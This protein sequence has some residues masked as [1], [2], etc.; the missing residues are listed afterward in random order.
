MVS[1]PT[2]GL[3]RVALV[4]GAGAAVVLAIVGVAQGSQSSPQPLSATEPATSATA[5]TASAPPRR[6]PTPPAWVDV[7]PV[8]ASASSP[9][10]SQ[11]VSDWV[12]YATHVIAATVVDET[13]LPL[14]EDEAEHNDGYV[15]RTATLQID[16]VVWESAHSDLELPDRIEMTVMGWSL[17]DGERRP[18]S[19]HNSP[20]IE[21][22]ET[23]LIP[24][25]TFDDGSW[26]VL[27][28]NVV[29]PVEDGVI[30]PLRVYETPNVVVVNQVLDGKSLSEAATILA[31]TEIRPNAE[32]Y[33]HL[34]PY[35]RARAVLGHDDAIEQ[36]RDG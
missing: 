33:M 23:L 24:L 8:A 32:P 19:G 7:P 31:N 4:I 9:F 22:G 6:S 12:T 29:F 30:R 15:G 17:D 14:Q 34:E 18:M 36:G 3:G 1:T 10:F 5:P 35:F 2:R 28:S 25:T 13:E 16:D 27:A 21:P 11:R 26:T 20:R